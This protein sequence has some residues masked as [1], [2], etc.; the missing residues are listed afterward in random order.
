M[1]TPDVI[2]AIA[3]SAVEYGKRM[4]RESPVTMIEDQLNDVKAAIRNLL[5]AIEEGILTASTKNRM[6]D[7]ED[8]QA[9]L[10][11]QLLA[12]QA[13][14]VTIDKPKVVAWLTQLQRGNIEDRDYLETLINTFVTAIYVYDDTLKVIFTYSG[15]GADVP[16][17]A[18]TDA[19]AAELSASHAVRV[20]SSLGHQKHHDIYRGVFFSLSSS[21]ASVPQHDLFLRRMRQ[22][23]QALQLAQ[24]MGR[25]KGRY[26]V[27]F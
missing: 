16:L 25:R 21:T 20:A 17:S 6:R 4:E 1:L 15:G 7:L 23:S 8:E 19:D 13:T 5:K 12:A 14:L 10:Q 24:H 11:R 18:I 26:I 3:D 22:F 27:V 2:D 9:D